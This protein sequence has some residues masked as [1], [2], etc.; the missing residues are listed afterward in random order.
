M[1]TVAASDRATT[2]RRHIRVLLELRLVLA[3]PRRRMLIR[4]C[5]I[6]KADR[7]WSLR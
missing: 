4:R 6:R 5:A 1:M 7:A 2:A 3:I